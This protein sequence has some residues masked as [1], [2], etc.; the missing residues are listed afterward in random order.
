MTDEGNV[1]VETTA[2]EATPV[3]SDSPNMTGDTVVINNQVNTVTSDNSGQ[4]PTQPIAETGAADIGVVEPVIPL[5]TPAPPPMVGSQLDEVQ[6]IEM[7]SQQAR[8]A[9]YGKTE[10][11]KAGFDSELSTAIAYNES[12]NRALAID[13]YYVKLNR[14]YK[15]AEMTGYF[16]APEDKEMITQAKMAEWQLS[17][18]DIT[19]AIR[20]RAEKTLATVDGY[21]NAKGISRQGVVTLD[22]IVK[23]GNLA[24][25]RGQNAVAAGNLSNMIRA[26]ELAN[27]QSV[28]A[29]IQTGAS[30]SEMQVRLSGIMSEEDVATIYNS[31]LPL[32]GAAKYANAFINNLTDEEFE[33]QTKIVSKSGD[34]EVR[35]FKKKNFDGVE[36]TY[37]IKKT[38]DLQTGEVKW[39]EDEE[40]TNNVEIGK[41]SSIKTITDKDLKAMDKADAKKYKPIAE[42]NKLMKETKDKKLKAELDKVLDLVVA[43]DSAGNDKY[44]FTKW[45]E[46][47]GALETR[48]G[49]KIKKFT[50]EPGKEMKNNDMVQ[51]ALDAVTIKDSTFEK[52]SVS[53]GQKVTTKYKAKLIQTGNKKHIY[54]LDSDNVWRTDKNLKIPE[55]YI[56]VEPS[57]LEIR[58]DSIVEFLSFPD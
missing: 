42:M 35:S 36:E 21:F 52:L 2:S 32:Y 54:Y 30:L 12:K 20:T 33:K 57:V 39:V 37:Y 26:A 38:V 27:I 55:E 16:L 18:A 17:Q 24:I 6:I 10:L 15:E 43:L 29:G 1:V 56:D 49:T 14:S 40:Y 11:A 13:E 44:Y 41:A 31:Y 50:F 51:K 25:Q 5:G 46:E 58:N 23:D 8:S 53:G 34:K 47:G 3:V 45:W 9:T 48:F 22:K 19:N 28:Y 7:M 4:T